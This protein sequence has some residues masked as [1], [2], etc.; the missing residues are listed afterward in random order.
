MQTEETQIGGKHV[1]ETSMLYLTHFSLVS[2]VC[3]WKRNLRGACNLMWH[4][5]HSTAVGARSGIGAVGP[6]PRHL[7][8]L[9]RSRVRHYWQDHRH[10][11]C[12]SIPALD[13]SCSGNETVTRACADLAARCSRRGQALCTLWRRR[14]GSTSCCLGRRYLLRAR[15]HQRG[16]GWRGHTRSDRGGRGSRSRRRRGSVRACAAG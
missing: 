13:D 15:C 3:Q 8:Q 1:Q 11:H 5:T 12:A 16:R 2:T 4:L 14:T 7:L 6:G 9:L 10:V